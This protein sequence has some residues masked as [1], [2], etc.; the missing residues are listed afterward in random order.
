VLWGLRIQE[1]LSLTETDLDQRR[2][3]ILVRHANNDRQ[4]E[5]GEDAWARS[6]IEPWLADRV[7][8]PVG[9]A[10]LCD[11]RANPRAGVVSQVRVAELAVDQR[12]R[13]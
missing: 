3:S 12:Q 10:L 4:R 9:A 5:V 13:D 2:G 7:K 11:R 6:A 8:L 1:T